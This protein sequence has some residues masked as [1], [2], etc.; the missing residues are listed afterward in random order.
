MLG[1]DSSGNEDIMGKFGIGQI[2]IRGERLIVFSRD[3]NLF[4][5]SKRGKSLDGPLME[6]L[7]A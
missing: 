3:N 4:V 7:P 5:T 6:G 2:N 1:N